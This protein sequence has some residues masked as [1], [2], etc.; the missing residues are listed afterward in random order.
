[1]WDTQRHLSIWLLLIVGLASL[2]PRMA[3]ADDL[4]FAGSCAA[5]RGRRDPLLAVHRPS[6]SESDRRGNDLG[7]EYPGRVE[8]WEVLQ[9]RDPGYKPPGRDCYPHPRP[10]PC[11][12][13]A[14]RTSLRSELTQRAHRCIECHPTYAA[15][16]RRLVVS[17]PPLA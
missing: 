12:R 3:S 4:N 16:G 6:R 9:H 7:T 10:C 2:R 13:S 8:G 17:Q 11:H 5:E 1:M 15:L 14:A